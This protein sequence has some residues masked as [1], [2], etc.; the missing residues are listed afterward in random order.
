M[1]AIT[2]PPVEFK[3]DMLLR[4]TMNERLDQLNTVNRLKRRAYEPDY[5]YTST[6]PI[7]T[8]VG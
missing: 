1:S 4:K 7:P 8:I 6:E 3:D 2:G 5:T